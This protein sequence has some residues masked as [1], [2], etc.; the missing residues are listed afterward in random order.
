MV[1]VQSQLGAKSE[2]FGR[3]GAGVGASPPGLPE[4]TGEG[5]GTVEVRAF[6]LCITQPLADN[7]C[8]VAGSAAEAVEEGGSEAL[9]SGE[10]ESESEGNHSPVRPASSNGGRSEFLADK[11]F[12]LAGDAALK[13]G[14]EAELPRWKTRRQRKL[15]GKLEAHARFLQ[16][17]FRQS[18]RV[19]SGCW[20][21][22]GMV[23]LWFYRP[24]TVFGCDRG[25]NLASTAEHDAQKARA[26]RATAWYANYVALLRRLR[27]GRTPSAVVGFCGQ[28]GV[29]E[30]IRRANGAAHGQD[31][32][33]QPRYKSRYG[34][35]TFTCGD[36]TSALALAD[37]RRR[38]GAFVT[39]ASPPCQS[40]SS[41]RM[42]G[43]PSD[44]PLIAQTRAALRQ[45]GGLHVI[46]NVVGAKAALG[47]ETCL[48]RGAYFGE[49][50]DRP[51][52]FEANFALRVDKAL[53]ESGNALRARTCLGGRRRWRRLDP[54]G[55]MEMQTCCQGNLWA[56]Q[57]D[58][59]LRCTTCEC[60]A[61]MGVDA[62]HMDYAG[63]SQ[64]I[65]P[66]YAQYIFGQACM[67][68]VER[69]FGL[70]AITFDDMLADP[71]R[72]RRVMA[73]MLRGAGGASS[74]QGVELVAPRAGS[75]A[76]SSLPLGAPNRSGEGCV[77]KEGGEGLAAAPEVAAGGAPIFGEPREVPGY[78]PVFAD[79]E[80]EQLPPATE[81]TVAEAEWRELWY[82][83]AGD[84]SAAVG[85]GAARSAL[86]PVRR[87]GWRGELGRDEALI[88][89]N[90][91]V[92]VS[93]E[94]LR[95]EAGRLASLAREHI[96]TRICVEAR[97]AEAERR[98]KA[99]GFE[100]VRRVAR[101][102]PAY[103]SGSAPA[104]SERPRSLWAIGEEQSEAGQRVDYGRVEEGMDPLDRRGAAQEPKTAKAARSYM[105]IPWQREQWDIGLPE[106]LD[107]I[108]AR[109]G[110]R[111][112]PAFELGP[113]EVPF[114]RWPSR[115][116]L[117]ES[118]V[119]ADRAL[120]AGAMEYVPAS[121]LAE[122]QAHSTVHPWTIVDQGGGKW[123]LCHDYSVGTNRCAPTAAFSM[124]S[125]WD[126]EPVIEAGS[127]FAKYDIRD[128]FWHV[129]I[130]EDSKKRLVVRHPGTGRLMWASRLPFGYLD[131]PRVFCSLTEAIVERLRRQAAGKGIHFYVFVDDVLVVGDTE[132]LTREGMRLLERE[133]AA[134]GVQWAPHKKRGPCRCIEFLGLL[135]CNLP[136]LR[137]ITLTEKR[138]LK[139]EA[140]MTSW[141][142]RRCGD[143][144]LEVEPRQ[145]ASILGKL[146]FASQVVR[147]GRTYMQGMLS[148]FQGLVVDWRRGTVAPAGGVW[149]TMTIGPRF[150]RDLAWWRRHL[151]TRSFSRLG[152]GRRPAEGVLSGTDASNWGTGQVLWL[153]GAREESVLRFTAAEVRRPINWRELLGVL[154]VCEVGG[155]RLRGRTLL[156]ETDNM[157]A[158]GATRKMA[159]K[160]EDMQELIRRIL[161][162][163]EAHGFRV[164]VTHTPGEKLDRPDQTSRGDAAEE[165]RA[166]LR[167]EVF[168]EVE[169]RWGPFSSFLGA[170]R[171]L[172]TTAPSGQEGELRRLWVH[173]TLSTVGTAMR[174]VQEEMAR[175]GPTAAVALALVPDDDAPAWSRLMR[176]GVV[177]G[178][179]EEG[180]AALEMNVLGAW[181][182]CQVQR[183]MRFVVFPRTAGGPPR[184]V[185]L[186]H[187]QGM[188]I[189]QRG[190]R[191]TTAGEGYLQMA[192]G[193]GLRLPVLAGSFVY[194]LPEVAGGCGGLYQVAEPTTSERASDPD[195]VIAVYALQNLSKAARKSKLPIFDVSTRAGKRWRPD[196][197]EL[198]AVD[199]LVSRSEVI[200]STFDRYTF[201]FEEANRQ[202]AAAGGSWG[203]GALSGWELLSVEEELSPIAPSS[204]ASGYVPFD[205]SVAAGDEGLEAISANLDQLHLE[206]HSSKSGPEGRVAPR[207]FTARGGE[208]AGESG[209]VIQICQY[210]GGKCGGC[211]QHFHLGERQRSHGTALVHD[212]TACMEAL[213]VRLAREMAVELEEGVRATAIFYGV[214]SDA[215]G[216]AGVYT[217]WDQVMAIVQCD[218][219]GRDGA[220]YLACT[221]YHEAHEYVRVCTLQR[222]TEIEG[223]ARSRGSVTLRTHMVEKLAPRRVQMIVDCIEGR[224]GIAHGPESTACKGGCGRHVHMM[225]CCQMGK[226]FAALGNFLCPAC[227]LAKI[228]VE[229]SE[230]PEQVRALVTKTMI[231]E[232]GQGAESTAAGFAEF[233]RLEREYVEG[234]GRLQDGSIGLVL[235]RH[236]AEAFKHFLSWM[237]LDADRSLSLQSFV[238][239]ASSFFGKLQ[240]TDHTKAPDVKA[241]VKDLVKKVGFEH[242]PATTATPRM[243]AYMTGRGVEARFSD[244]FIRARERVQVIAE[245]VGGCRIG[246]VCGGGEAHGLLANHTAILEDL[247]VG[248][249]DET[250]GRVVVEM[251]L[252]HSKTGF[253]R[254]LDLAGTT[255]TSNIQCAKY[256][257]DYWRLAGMTTTTQVESGI[258][259]TR[260]DFWVVR[261][262][263]LGM[264]P[265]EGG[266]FERLCAWLEASTSPAVKRTV[267]S[268]LTEAKGQIG[269]EGDPQKK[270]INVAMGDSKT[271]GLRELNDELK[272]A[273]FTSTLVE[274]PLLLATTGGKYPR[275][276]TMPLKTSSAFAPTKELL[277]QAWKAANADP[278]NPDPALELAAGEKP[279]W[280]SHSLRR[281]ADTT[282]RRYRVLMNITE[283][284]ID[285][286]FGWNERVLLKAMQ[287]HYAK[288]TRRERMRHARITGMM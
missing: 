52:L 58:K 154:R 46:E 252:E 237:S 39:F 284:E 200:G 196:P 105:P 168:R 51:R 203:D 99:A 9:E 162:L 86:E 243:L 170:E 94:A 90:T 37:L 276:K 82:S 213:D 139:L 255:S 225:S 285:I 264:R 279:K 76:L 177:V 97:G 57:G 171:E 205:A 191:T 216:E 251:M 146:V 215:I 121:R 54:F 267:K 23:G 226:G 25:R 198:W 1:D 122:V 233:T 288:M 249:G 49:H 89:R 270:Y 124:P 286:Y 160:A 63:L 80:E 29:T 246:E 283:A 181:Q 48:L 110:L 194:S 155:E 40:Y 142:E 117:F 108:M 236:N 274:G 53:Q 106:E 140:E 262:S 265:G 145:L 253:S 240:L 218:S 111:I 178:R 148:S 188:E 100:L 223:F 189:V 190:G 69:E 103:A 59:P 79:G 202:I 81:S 107:E 85:G 275:V 228:T 119:E 150:W 256:L 250:L 42:R 210:A 187:R 134:R 35:E 229:G 126:V 47:G 166:R 149:Q 211:D 206:Q 176:H 222:A 193:K 77:Q 109:H 224:C 241:F 179:L 209:P 132:E 60:A 115:E 182:P 208:R 129:P 260:P 257:R 153:D 273:G 34:D 266:E 143:A 259:V 68:E 141:A 44:P 277:T 87:I 66:V 67:R 157:A 72:A 197:S 231:L 17:Y 28:G 235:P 169:A 147:G 174:R 137:G 238:R 195:A 27:S 30:G 83:W 43:E 55:R 4:D 135:I 36:S 269:A 6:K 287:V 19:R 96:G 41:A 38:T 21:R 184:R 116:G 254:Y 230:T 64:A 165:P 24:R 84:F 186:T 73:H 32:R 7:G 5:T 98:V 164:R 10:C 130:A 207:V 75:G 62:D 91:L 201:D 167:P 26:R 180:S 258:R 172:A 152:E 95:R 183:P 282:A 227:R 217:E 245:G 192:L 65:P 101:G 93:G 127:H 3:E 128:G 20:Q 114:Y 113:S 131:A 120:A 204:T 74:Q 232:M 88:G 22:G 8:G 56:V 12:G 161:R 156:I 175:E 263:L 50:V 118:I 104:R 92:L 13:G 31:L 151:A 242:V 78:A 248:A 71:A 159:S 158:A 219:A 102:S 281:L 2:G 136:G 138:L 261:V 212:T 280:S 144:R 14:A 15:K 185:A 239:T 123:R 234:F 247:S 214:Y 244:E 173:P 45:V 278:L 11:G 70:E 33:E 112:Q 199:H 133:F 18:R 268:T 163:G 61:A 271:C 221:S 125:V 220:S 272:A 16:F